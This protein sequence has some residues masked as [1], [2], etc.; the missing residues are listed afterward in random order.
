M[1]ATATMLAKATKL[2]G[3]VLVSEVQQGILRNIECIPLSSDRIMVV[4][5]MDSGIIRSM[6][7]NLEITIDNNDLL[8]IN[9]ILNEYLTGVSLKDIQQTAHHRLRN[10]IVYNHE[11]VQILLQHPRESF[12]FPTNNLIYTS[13]NQFLF[14][15]SDFQQVN[16][17]QTF[18]NALETQKIKRILTSE[19]II[20]NK[21]MLIGEENK[22]K[23]FNDFSILSTKFQSEYLEGKLAIF[24]PKRIPYNNIKTILEHFSEIITHVC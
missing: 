23:T 18:L 4:L 5:A 7:F 2:F 19:N 20:N 11:I 3:V 10:T 15:H 1:Q 12:S 24:G 16:K 9:Q 6:V 21:M 17:M 13:S 8:I 14:S 22:D